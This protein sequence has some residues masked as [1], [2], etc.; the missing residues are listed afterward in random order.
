MVTVNKTGEWTAAV[1]N[2]ADKGSRN[3]C[4]AIVE[5]SA[6]QLSLPTLH[7]LFVQEAPIIGVQDV[8][9]GVLS[10]TKRLHKNDFNVAVGE[11]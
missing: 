8:I 7:V 1:F 9:S 4:R 5:G 10:D 3:S 6:H 2:F 11:A